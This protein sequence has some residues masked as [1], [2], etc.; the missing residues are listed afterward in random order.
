MKKLLNTVSLSFA[1][2]LTDTV[3]SMVLATLYG[4]FQKL[5]NGGQ[6]VLSYPEAAMLLGLA[7][8]VFYF[9]IF[10]VL[11]YFLNRYLHWENKLAK[12]VVLNCG[13]YLLISFLFGFILEPQVQYLFRDEFFFILIAST[14]LS[15]VVLTRL[16]YAK[17]L[18]VSL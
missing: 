15:P 3:I 6:S 12:L 18:V 2:L 10:V 11:F 13:L 8:L 7:R 17:R 16:P 4:F 9:L 1:L 14:I 5:N